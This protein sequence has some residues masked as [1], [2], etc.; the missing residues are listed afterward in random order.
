MFRCLCLTLL[1][2]FFT[3]NGH[4][5]VVDAFEVLLAEATRALDLLLGARRVFDT[6][7]N[8]VE[9]LEALDQDAKVVISCGEPF[10]GKPTHV[11][12]MSSFNTLLS[13]VRAGWW[14]QRRKGGEGCFRFFPCFGADLSNPPALSRALLSSTF[15]SF[16]ARNFSSH[17]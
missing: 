10:A 17:G 7:G 8:E 5:L 15:V 4:T 16:C 14:P 9:S 1:L 6:D 2:F 13:K 11:R 3:Q 12:D